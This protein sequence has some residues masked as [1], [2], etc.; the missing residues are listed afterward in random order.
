MATLGQRELGFGMA[1]KGISQKR[2]TGC[3]KGLTKISAVLLCFLLSPKISNF[4]NSYSKSAFAI[5]FD[6]QKK[7]L[8]QS[9]KNSSKVHLQFQVHS[10]V[11]VLLLSF[12]RTSK[13]CSEREKRPFFLFSQIFQ[14]HFCV[15][16]EKPLEYNAHFVSH[17]PSLCQT[18][19]PT[20]NLLP[21][22]RS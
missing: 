14:T 5:Q 22:V 20:L 4:E 7:E 9:T 3:Q 8:H 10:L 11:V 15:C 6:R 1:S 2:L 17:M 16:A 19:N 21:D 18:N 13:K 12:Q